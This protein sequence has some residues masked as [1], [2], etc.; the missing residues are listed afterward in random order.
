MAKSVLSKLLPVKTGGAKSM[1]SKD[2]VLAKKC[3]FLF[4]LMT[5]L[6]G[7]DDKP[8]Q[9]C[10]VVI[11]AEDGLWKGCLSEKNLDMNLWA[12]SDCLVGVLEALEARLNADVIEWRAKPGQATRR[13]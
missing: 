2:E 6:Q 13:K 9:P 4:A 11:F 7:D 8:R 12:S 10:S 1:K 5:E 3:P